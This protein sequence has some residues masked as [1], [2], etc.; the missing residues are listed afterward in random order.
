VSGGA[1]ILPKRVL[2]ALQSQRAERL[3][4]ETG[5]FLLGMRRGRH[6]EITHA[7]VQG[8]EDEA[9]NVSFERRDPGHKDRAVA[10]W[11]ETNGIIGLVGDWHTHPF[12]PPIPSTTDRAAWRSLVSSIGHSAVGIILA[13]GSPGVFIAPKGWLL[14]GAQRC[15]T[16]EDINE[17][18]VFAAG[19]QHLL[20]EDDLGDSSRNMRGRLSPLIRRKLSPWPKRA[21]L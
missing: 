10:I 19:V 2:A 18:I 5:G 13:E 7:T 17:E 9:T 3:P 6:I 12:G 1:V 16:L 20:A 14:S 4:R 8:P 15:E 11:E 21:D